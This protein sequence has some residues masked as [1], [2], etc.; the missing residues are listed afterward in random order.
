MV[1]IDTALQ[2]IAVS[3]VLAVVPGPDNLFVLMQS[4][5]GGA[6]KGIAVTLGLCTGLVVHTAAVAFG[7][8][9]IFQ[10]SAAA[11]TALKILGATYLLYLAYGALT[12]GMDTPVASEGLAG[13]GRDNLTGLYR[14]GI[15]MN[16]TNPKVALFFL[17]FLPQFVK[18]GA[19]PAALQILQLGG[20]FMM[21]ALMIFSLIA[22]TAGRLSHWL[23]RSP[24]AIKAMN[25]VAG[26]VFIGLAAKL[27]AAQR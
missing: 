11:F 9:A 2:F 25:R 24:K 8:A 16:I 20:L 22:Y 7:V 17:A 18:A 10:A 14:R 27:A 6:R 4:A 1:S 15:L 3:A 23:R 26:I 21:T 13:A 19:G 5:A 12:S